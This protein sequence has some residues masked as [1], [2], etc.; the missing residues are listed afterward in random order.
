VP[1]SRT[2]RLVCRGS[3]ILAVL[4]HCVWLGQIVSRETLT[5]VHLTEDLRDN[6]EWVFADGRQLALRA[7]PVPELIAFTLPRGG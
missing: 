2:D 1:S 6:V 4:V 3:G 5:K 7:Q